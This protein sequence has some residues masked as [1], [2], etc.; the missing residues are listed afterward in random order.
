MKDIGVLYGKL[1]RPFQI[2]FT[3]WIL[4]SFPSFASI[5]WSYFTGQKINCNSLLGIESNEILVY[6]MSFVGG[7]IAYYLAPFDNPDKFRLKS[8]KII[9]LISILILLSGSFALVL[10]KCQLPPEKNEVLFQ[11]ICYAYLGVMLLWFWHT[12]IESPPDIQSIN[13]K[14]NQESKNLD[15]KFAAKLSK[16]S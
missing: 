12:L 10:L 1:I 14:T 5:A 2:V 3:T 16:E 8:A 9:C 6:A 13:Q 15:S 7:I 11:F 4:C